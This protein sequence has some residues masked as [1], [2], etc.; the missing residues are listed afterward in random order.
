VGPARIERCAPPSPLQPIKFGQP[1][2]SIPTQPPRRKKIRKK[3]RTG[4]GGGNHQLGGGEE[5][6]VDPKKISQVHMKFILCFFDI[7]PKKSIETNLE[8]LRSFLSSLRNIF[9]ES[10]LQFCKK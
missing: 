10:V 6:R 3:A 2:A 8:S 7:H 1:A 9:Y 4:G 5:S